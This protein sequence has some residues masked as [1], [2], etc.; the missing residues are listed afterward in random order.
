M[1]LQGYSTTEIAAELKSYDRKIRRVIE[2]IEELAH[3]NADAN[4]KAN[5]E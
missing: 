5:P 4:K 2:R 3:E 1:R